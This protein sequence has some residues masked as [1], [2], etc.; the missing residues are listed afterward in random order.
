MYIFETLFILQQIVSRGEKKEIKEI[1]IIIMENKPKKFQ[2]HND[3][4]WFVYIAL[5]CAGSKLGKSVLLLAPIPYN[6]LLNYIFTSKCSTHR[7]DVFFIFI[8]R[9]ISDAKPAVVSGSYDSNSSTF[10]DLIIIQCINSKGRN[11]GR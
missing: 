3:R 2:S 4:N 11:F 6:I 7:F 5:L 8:R 1:F 9:N 10:S